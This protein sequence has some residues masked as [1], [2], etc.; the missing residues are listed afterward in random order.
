MVQLGEMMFGRYVYD[1]FGIEYGIMGGF[2]MLHTAEP[3]PLVLPTMHV[4]IPATY[5][6][7]EGLRVWALTMDIL[8]NDRPTDLPSRDPT[9]PTV[10]ACIAAH[11]SSDVQRIR[12]VRKS[13]VQRIRRV[14]RAGIPRTGR[15]HGD[16]GF[17]R[18]SLR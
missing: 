15:S 11:P 5:A 1:R 4:L 2:H 18:R 8:F 3:P 16:E 14:H 13:T 6:I 10:H 17:L 7:T 9:V 12:P